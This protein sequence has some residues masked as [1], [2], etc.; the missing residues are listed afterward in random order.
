ME[1]SG[2]TKRKF[3]VGT[4]AGLLLFCFPSLVW[5]QPN[6]K[7]QRQAEAKKIKRQVEQIDQELDEAVENYNQANFKL[8]KIKAEF[9]DTS[10][11]LEKAQQDLGDRR[12]ILNTRLRSIY[13]HGE[14]PFIETIFSTKTFG[15]FLLTLSRLQDIVAS[16]VRI[17]GDIERLKKDVEE[18]RHELAE[19]EKN[20]K[21][22]CSKL[23]SNKSEIEK[24]LGERKN[25]L[26]GVEEE[27]NA[28][29]REEQASA[30]RLR[31]QAEQ[32]QVE[33]RRARTPQVSRGTKHVPAP[34][35]GALG[36]AMQQLGKPYRWGGAGPGSFDCS[37]LVMYSYAKIGVSL[38]HSA[39]AQYGYGTHISRDQL[40][41][42]DLVF[43]TRGRG[44]SH[45]G[46]YVGGDSYI[47]APRTGDVVK[48]SSL[49][50]RGRGYVGGVRP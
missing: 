5:G 33:Q 27:I 12:N 6:Q 9:T 17:V 10:Q 47:H 1:L 45:V 32:A 35:S 49:S 8:S 34:K 14:I 46:M 24:M 42:G 3:L 22:A 30:E 13:K 31:A 16:D 28:L 36:V 23:S 20:Q 48:I 19:Q 25:T 26:A 29:D 4:V 2:S 21:V 40:R 7:D 43:F 18:K 39:A 37:G 41:P 11:K 50:A 38:P 44:I 15:Q